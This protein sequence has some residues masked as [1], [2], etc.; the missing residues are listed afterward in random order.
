MF[1]LSAQPNLP[2]LAALDRR[3]GT[4]TAHLRLL[5]QA[6]AA[7]RIEAPAGAARDEER[8]GCRAGAPLRPAGTQTRRSSARPDPFAY[9]LYMFQSLFQSLG[10]SSGMPRR[11][12]APAAWRYRMSSMTRNSTL[13]WTSVYSLDR[14][15]VA[16][17]PARSAPLLLV[18]T[19]VGEIGEV[20]GGPTWRQ[21]NGSEERRG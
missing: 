7:I 16:V 21:V 5:A 8:P 3:F 12:T 15:A 14:F 4:R 1:V 18:T 9:A 13:A 20:V 17:H 10:A 19:P 6:S 11:P 2:G